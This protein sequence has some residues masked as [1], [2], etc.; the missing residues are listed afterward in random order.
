MKAKVIVR[1]NNNNIFIF[2]ML[3]HKNISWAN[4]LD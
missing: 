2:I 4:I 3:L 1:Y